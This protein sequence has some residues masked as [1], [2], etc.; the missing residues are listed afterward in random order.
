M[1]NLTRRECLRTL[2]IGAGSMAIA[3]L[4]GCGDIP[5]RPDESYSGE[6]GAFVP[7]VEL[8]LTATDASAGI[9]PGQPTRVLKYTGSVTKGDSSSLQ[10][11]EDCYLGPIIR[12]RRGQKIRIHFK[13]DLSEPTII[14][15]H[16]LHVP[17]E[18]D[19]QPRHVIS[20]GQS[21]VYDLEIRNHAG[22]YWYHPHPDRHTGPQVYGGLAGLFMVADDEEDALNL[23]GGEFDVPLV[24]QDRSFNAANQLLYLTGGMMNMMTSMTGFLGERILVNGRPDFSLSVAAHPYRL[25]LLNGSNSRVYKLA[26]DDGTPVTVI[27]TD[28]GLLEKPAQRNYVTLGP[29]ERVELWADFSNRPVGSEVRLKS[30]EFSG[31]ESGMMGMRGGMAGGGMMG[32]GG[33]MQGGSTPL[34]NGA[35]FPILRVK[36]DRNASNK[37]SLPDRLRTI[38]RY[39]LE[40]A[41]NRLMPRQF[42]IGMQGMMTWSINGRTFEMN[43]VTKDETVSL[44]TLEVWEFVNRTDGMAQMT[45]PMHIHGLQFQV[46]ERQIAPENRTAWE[47]VRLGYVDE[48]WKDTV[49]LWPGERIK[50]LMRF[51]DYRG[52]YMYHCHNLEHEDQGLMR[53]YLVQ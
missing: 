8:Q 10:T 53:N 43:G 17:P 44:N 34:S 12:V 6:A 47:T 11:V 13:N 26:W 20:G 52:M 14:H 27:A 45:H 15:W 38:Q 23:P 36:I 25:R 9:F 37:V 31:A 21:L 46:L 41:A 16:G 28:G 39:R 5:Q 40:D 49:L 7:D 18:M 50:L 48:G 30:L 42:Q 24:I 4:S 22:T 29:A 51:E 3:S 1:W 35:E 32:S 19:G 33:M 2:G